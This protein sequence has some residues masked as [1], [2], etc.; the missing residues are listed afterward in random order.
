MSNQVEHSDFI[1]FFIKDLFHHMDFFFY[2]LA[3]ILLGQPPECRHTSYK[4]KVCLFYETIYL[5]KAQKILTR[6]IIEV[7]KIF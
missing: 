1:F 4:H 2:Y 6:I 3:N 7:K 5:K